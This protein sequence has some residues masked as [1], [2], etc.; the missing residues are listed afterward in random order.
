M[1]DTGHLT[2][3]G[4][5]KVVRWGK[6]RLSSTSPLEA[7]I[8]AD[9]KEGTRCIVKTHVNKRRKIMVIMPSCLHNGEP[10]E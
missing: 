10:S 2:E 1:N 9:G 8:K 6:D 5:N 3:K 4:W 7:W